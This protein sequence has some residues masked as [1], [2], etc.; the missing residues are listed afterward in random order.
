[1]PRTTAERQVAGEPSAPSRTA[2]ALVGE[3]AISLTNQVIVACAERGIALMPLKGALL[4]AR[5]PILRGQRD[6]VDVDF[7]VRP[8][9]IRVVGR[10]LESLGFEETVRTSAG[11]TFSSEAWPLSIDIHRE[12]FPHGM[13]DVSTEGVFSRS[14]LDESLFAAGVARMSDDDVFAHLIGHFVK[15]RGT[16]PDDKSLGDLRWLLTQ[17]CFGLEDSDRLGVHLRGLGLRRAAGYVLGDASFRDEP[18]AREVLRALELSRLDHVT[19][20]VARFATGSERA[21]LRWWT[22]HLLDR[23]LV[24]GSRSLLTHA[25]EAA[26]RLL[27]RGA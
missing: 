26:H 24:A 18:V 17:R 27:G 14:A 1:M 20:A 13:F 22:P 8:E 23:S 4:L 16:F 2:T 25:D 9:D 21:L 7:L 3:L 5:W 15:G 12:L 6:L 19:V 11:G 10:V